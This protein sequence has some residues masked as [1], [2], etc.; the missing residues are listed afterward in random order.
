MWKHKNFIN[1][2]LYAP[3]PHNLTVYF[4]SNIISVTCTGDYGDSDTW[5]ESGT[6]MNITSGKTDIQYFTVQLKEGYVLDS[7]TYTEDVMLQLNDVTDNSF[8]ISGDAGQLSE[9]TLT[10]KAS[11]ITTADIITSIKTHIQDAYTSLE[12][13]SATIPTNKNIANLKSS[14]ESISVGVDT[15]DATATSA[16]ILSGKTAYVAGQKVTGAI[17]TYDGTV[18]DVGGGSNA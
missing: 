17:E 3:G 8:N 15:S 1:L 6:T 10:S 16:D 7:I 11:K 5:T 12:N 13:K 18:E 4:D 2:Q 14:I 9:V